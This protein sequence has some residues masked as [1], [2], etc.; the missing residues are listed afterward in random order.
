MAGHS[1]WAKVKRAKGASDAKRGKLFSR[2]AREIAM[3]AKLGG[4]D[5]SFNPRLRQAILTAKSE[6]VPNDTIERAVKKGTGELG[7]IA[8]EEMLYEG[9]GTGGV[10]MIVEAATDNKNRAAAEIRSLFSKNNGSLAAP[11]SVAW[12]FQYRGLILI[13]QGSASEEA[14]MEAALDAGAEDIRTSESH[15]EVITPTDKL[16]AVDD[17]LKKGGIASESSKFSY[18]P[19]NLTPVTD[20]SAAR[21]VL[22]LLD[23]LEDHEDVQNVYSNLDISEELAAKLAG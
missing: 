1:H 20:E 23:A 6:S 10:A 13:P 17:A 22:A 3:A 15:F 21:Q 19:N 12:M 8:I 11:G 16:Y 7:G 18:L 9:Y 5:S 4:G 2:L 14:I